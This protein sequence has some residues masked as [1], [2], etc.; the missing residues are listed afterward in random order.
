MNLT[1]DQTA[2]QLKLNRSDLT[3]TL[4]EKGVLDASNIPQGRFAGKGFFVVPQCSYLH[5][6]NGRTYYRKTLV[7]EK[8]LGLIESV[9]IN[10]KHTI[11]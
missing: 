8:G 1:L 2:K 5:P 6:R 3:K 9:L 10:N 11:H 4:R 7:T